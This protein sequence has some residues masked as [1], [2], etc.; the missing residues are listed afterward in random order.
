MNE[1]GL[2]SLI[3]SDAKT[4]LSHNGRGISQ[5]DYIL[6]MT[7]DILFFYL[8]LRNCGDDQFL[9]ITSEALEM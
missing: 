1:Q 8:L 7:P 6:Y 2:I 4:F 9:T 5:I 3:D